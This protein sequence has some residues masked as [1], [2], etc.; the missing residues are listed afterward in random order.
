MENNK[1]QKTLIVMMIILVGATVSAYECQDNMEY[2]NSPCEVVTPVF[3]TSGV[4]NASVLNINNSNFNQTG[5][6]LTPVGDGTNNFTFNN[7]AIGTYSITISCNNYSA[8]IN[9][10]TGTEEQE[11]GFNLWLILFAIFFALI[12][13]GLYK[14]NYIMIFISG[15]L[16]LLMGVYVFKDGITVYGVTYWWVYPLGWIF[17]GLGIII[18]IVSSIKFMDVNEYGEDDEYEG[19]GF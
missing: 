5:V 14:R 13:V 4:C 15:S 19:G 18:T 16:S 1:I 9:L 2:W 3:N 7:T 8:T 6:I 17:I 10:N 11:P 12:I